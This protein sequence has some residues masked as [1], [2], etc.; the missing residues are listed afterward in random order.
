[1]LVYAFKLDEC[2]SQ[3]LLAVALLSLLNVD[4]FH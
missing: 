3:S 1:M 4:L 2:D